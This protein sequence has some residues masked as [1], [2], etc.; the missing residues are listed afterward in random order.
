MRFVS[1]IQDKKDLEEY[2]DKKIKSFKKALEQ[3]QQEFEEIQAKVMPSLDHDMFKIK[4]MND[5]AMPHRQE[6]EAKQAELD[7]MQNEIF[8]YKREVALLKTKLEEVKLENEKDVENLK[9][10]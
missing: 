9:Q 7:E 8:N 3:R 1:S 10:R 5:V 4:L 6:M 2:Y